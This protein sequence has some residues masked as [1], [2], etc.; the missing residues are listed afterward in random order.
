MSKQFSILK[1]HS[2]FPFLNLLSNFS[3]MA[4]SNPLYPLWNYVENKPSQRYE[5]TS[6]IHCNICPL[7]WKGHYTTVL[8][9]TMVDGGNL[10]WM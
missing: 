5:G 4:S 3:I 1:L 7:K 9:A 10:P 6:L 8:I 2:K